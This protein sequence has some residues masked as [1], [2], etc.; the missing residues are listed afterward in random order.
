MQKRGESPLCYAKQQQ[1][2]SAELKKR[3]TG[4]GFIDIASLRLVLL[5][6][7]M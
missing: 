7:V 4:M 2:A 6:T 1:R 5:S 3:K